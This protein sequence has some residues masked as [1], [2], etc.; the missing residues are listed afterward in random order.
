MSTAAYYV[1]P[2]QQTTV[3]F[4]TD[5]RAV[6]Y[7]EMAAALKGLIWVITTILKE[8]TMIILYTDSTVVYYT[9]VKGTGLTLR[10]SPL[11]QQLFV[12]MYI[13]KNKAGH[14]LVVQWVPSAQNLA[15]PL[16]R[17]VHADSRQSAIGY[18]SRL[19]P[20]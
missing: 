18:I 16:T 3:Q 5:H 11:L 4:Y 1:G 7:T 17:G 6:A 14:G 20:G 12:K 13:L 19:R 8:P 10:A 9:I 2:P 15:D